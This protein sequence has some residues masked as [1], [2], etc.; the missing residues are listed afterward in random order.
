MLTR[1]IAFVLLTATTVW[2]C[3]ASPEIR[4]S[5][6]TGVSMQLPTRVE[7]FVGTPGKPDP[8]EVAILP[9]DTEF[10]KMSYRREGAAPLRDDIA[11]VSIVLAGADRRSI[12]RP[13]VC[14]QG[15][16]WTI[17]ASRVLPV[18]MEGGRNLRVKDL[19]LSKAVPSPDG[20]NTR[21]MRAHYLYWFAGAG[22]STP[23][24][25]ERTW[26][27]L[28]DNV[29]S[30]INHRWAY[31]SVMGLVTEGFSPQETGQRNR[32]DEETEAMLQELIRELAPKFQ[33]EFMPLAP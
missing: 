20:T 12:H 27:T 13:E 29:L 21:I 7:H 24:H 8:A 15:Q 25:G 6:E 16:G 23:E 10:A 31:A 18:N 26:I 32:S 9:K 11:H 2:L 22:V 4:S 33:K 17:L 5:G 19:Y 14:L 30:G 28:R 1:S 3:K